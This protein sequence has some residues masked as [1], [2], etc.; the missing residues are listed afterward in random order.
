ME[1][2][3]KDEMKRIKG[4]GISVWVMVGI[5]AAIVFLSGIID[6]FVH[7]ESC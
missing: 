1:T 4:G 6:G 7:P 3:K 5:G 2:L